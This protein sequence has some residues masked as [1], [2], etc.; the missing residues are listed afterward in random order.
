MKKIILC[1][2]VLL[3][4]CTFQTKH[5]GYVFPDDLASQVADVKTTTALIEK[6]GVW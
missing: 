6:I 1:A 4:A 5:R 2:L 3:S